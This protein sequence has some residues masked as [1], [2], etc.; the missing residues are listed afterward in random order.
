MRGP[1]MPNNS[2]PAASIVGHQSLI[3]SSGLSPRSRTL[4]PALSDL[5]GGQVDVMFDTLAQSI[6]YI[7]AG[8]MRAV[9][10]TTVARVDALPDVPALDEFV[11]GYEAIAFQG[12]GA[13]RN[14]RP[15]I[16]GKLNSE[17]N[18]GLANPRLAAR[19]AALG[20]TALAGSAAEF[21]RFIDDEMQ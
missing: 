19:L 4:P 13:P 7:K 12:I 6:E 16:I 21:R 9:N 5:L 2:A 17:I 8:K 14:T 11:P 10:V 3:A 1:H 15:E 20:G 18:A